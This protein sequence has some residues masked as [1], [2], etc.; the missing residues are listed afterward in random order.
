MNPTG[1]RIAALALGLPF[2]VAVAV[3]GAFSMV[4]TF[5]RASERHVAS[6]QWSGGAIT[7]RTTGDITV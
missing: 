4:G 3:F 1:G 2:V 6:Y 5:A 7:L